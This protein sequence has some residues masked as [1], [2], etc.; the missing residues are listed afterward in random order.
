M[1]SLYDKKEKKGYCFTDNTAASKMIGMSRHK[2][3]RCLTN[4]LW[5]GYYEDM[6]WIIFDSEVIKSRRGVCV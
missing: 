4:K 3:I 5:P 6:Y 2:L 1:V